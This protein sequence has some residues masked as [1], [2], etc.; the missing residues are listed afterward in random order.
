MHVYQENVVVIR[1]GCGSQVG[2]MTCICCIS[3]RITW[4]LV[5]VCVCVCMCARAY[6]HVICGT[7]VRVVVISI[8]I[9]HPRCCQRWR[10]EFGFTSN[11]ACVP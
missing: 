8:I 11:M 1:T 2:H 7:H 4:D 10:H 3:W 9:A 5:G 6:A